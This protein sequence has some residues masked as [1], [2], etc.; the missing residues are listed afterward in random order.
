M[1]AASELTLELN[2]LVA[3]ERQRPP[4]PIV[5]PLLRPALACG[6]GDAAAALHIIPPTSVAVHGL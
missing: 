5:E 1:A 4:A 3:F 6:I 2:Q